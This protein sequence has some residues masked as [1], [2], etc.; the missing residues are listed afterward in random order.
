MSTPE[1]RLT[2]TERAHEIAMAALSRSPR[3]PEGNVELSLNAKGDV[4][5]T[6]GAKGSDVVEVALAVE[7]VFDE[8]RAKYPRA[9]PPPPTDPDVAQARK[10]AGI[11]AARARAA[12]GGSSDAG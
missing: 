2:P 11:Q 10:I 5:I 4:Q 6:V 1:R 9:A 8:L 7:T 3:E 12:Q